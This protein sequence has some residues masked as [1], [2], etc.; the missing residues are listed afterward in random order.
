MAAKMDL[1]RQHTQRDETNE[2]DEASLQDAA[3]NATE[4]PSRPKSQRGI[5]VFLIE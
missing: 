4:T 3:Q 2:H 5:T 1:N